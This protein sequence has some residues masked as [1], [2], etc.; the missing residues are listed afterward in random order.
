[1]KLYLDCTAC[2]FDSENQTDYG[3]V[4]E[5]NDEGFYTFECPSGHK[6]F[7][8]LQNLKFEILFEIGANAILDGYY[9]ESVSCFTASLEQFYEFCLQVF[10]KKNNVSMDNYLKSWKF[11]SNSS[12]RQFGAFVYSYLN[13]FN[14]LPLNPK[15]EKQKREFRNNVI[16]KGT[17]PT[18]IDVIDYGDYV[19]NIINSVMQKLRESMYSQEMEKV[20]VENM[21]N[22]ANQNHHYDTSS[23]IYY[24]TIITPNPNYWKLEKNLSDI[25]NGLKTKTARFARKSQV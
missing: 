10:S 18:K 7:V 23:V 8:M 14:E 5:Y 22:K 17:I 3:V 9:R 21:I 4:V 11:L 25:L 1:M 15:I 12:E 19:R 2:K 6:N 24:P 13:E 16:H 20:I